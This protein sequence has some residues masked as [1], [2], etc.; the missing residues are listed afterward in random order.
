MKRNILSKIESIDNG[1]STGGKEQTIEVML[2]VG[3]NW[4]L[5]RFNEFLQ[6]VALMVIPGFLFIR[7]TYKKHLKSAC[8]AC[9]QELWVC[10]TKISNP[11]RIW[12]CFLHQFIQLFST[13]WNFTWLV[14]CFNSYFFQ[15]LRRFL[16]LYS[17]HL[18][19]LRWEIED[20]AIIMCFSNEQSAM[21][22]LDM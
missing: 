13:S 5:I 3:H 6:R 18:K 15:I 21:Q 7:H 12:T 2:E 8:C 11:S 19:L 9:Y 1:W 22:P 4:L 14:Q 16:A 20:V 17:L 10:P